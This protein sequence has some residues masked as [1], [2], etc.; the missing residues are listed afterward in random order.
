MYKMTIALSVMALAFCCLWSYGVDWGVKY[1]MGT[2]NIYGDDAHYIIDYSISTVVSGAASEFG[3][4]RLESIDNEH[5]VSHNLGVYG[6]IKLT[7][8]HDSI[9]L[10][11]EMIWQR[12]RYTQKFEGKTLNT[13]NM[14]LATEFADTLSG[15]IERTQDY[16]TIPVLIRLQQEVASA[17]SGGYYTGAFVYA[18]PSISLLLSNKSDKYKGIKALDDD[19]NE[20]VSNSQTDSDLSQYYKSQYHDNGADKLLPYK[21]DIVMGFGF[22]LKDLFRFGF[23]KDA[24]ILD[25]RF[26][27]GINPVGDAPY[28]TEFKLRSVVFSLGMKL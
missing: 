23:G 12:Y 6:S 16:L 17:V 18:G 15:K 22:G 7:N 13:N 2:S 20:F 11:S 24:F 19:I 3:Y 1:G 9:R 4:L 10:Q 26:T 27:M 21:F 5:G 14:F 8:N 28:Q 25:C